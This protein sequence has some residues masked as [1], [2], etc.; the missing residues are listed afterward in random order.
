MKL[1]RPLIPVPV[2]AKSGAARPSSRSG[3]VVS[4]G[5]IGKNYMDTTACL[6]SRTIRVDVI[7]LRPS[8]CYAIGHLTHP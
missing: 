7:G 6:A 3:G 5:K 8:F 2:R 1:L 4:V